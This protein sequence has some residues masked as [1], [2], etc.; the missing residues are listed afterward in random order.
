[1]KI[2]RTG[3]LGSNFTGSYEKKEYRARLAVTKK[4]EIFVLPDH[5]LAE[6]L[7]LVK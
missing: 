1:M 5:Q 7:I 4:T 3:S 6:S 2:L